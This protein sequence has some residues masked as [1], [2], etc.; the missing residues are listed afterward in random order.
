MNVLV[1]GDIVGKVGVEAVKKNIANLKE[2]YNIDFTIVNGE[3]SAEGMGITKKI[4]DTLYEVG[5]DVITMGNHTWGKKDIFSFIDEEP[6]LIRPLNYAEGLPGK[7]VYVTTIGMNKI[8]VID[9]IGRVN[10]GGSFDSPFEVA[11]KEIDKLKR[12]GVNIIIVEIHAEA[13]AEKVALGYYLRDKATIVY[14]THTH[15]QTAD[16]KILETGLG[17]ITDVGMTGPKNSIIGMD[18]D[19]ALKRFLTQMPERYACAEGE[20]MLNAVVFEIDDT[21]KKVSKIE[22]IS[23]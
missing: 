7:G 10:V 6:R 17:Y 8:A 18:P 13:T 3:N 1:I 12:E 2:K 21:T 16:E 4:A 14:G 11:S 15:I 5:T 20:A 23:L 19:A 22:R 9:L